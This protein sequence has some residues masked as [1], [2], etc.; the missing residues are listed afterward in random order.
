MN[1][2]RQIIAFLLTCIF[3]IGALNGLKLL[4]QKRFSL[5]ALCFDTLINVLGMF[6]GAFIV[7]VLTKRYTR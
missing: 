2:K 7:Y 4:S 5:S 6:L 1:N 3:T